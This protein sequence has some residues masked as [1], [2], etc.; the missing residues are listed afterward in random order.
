MKLWIASIGV[1]LIWTAEAFA[2]EG[3]HLLGPPENNPAEAVPPETPSSS[4]PASDASAI[5]VD[6]WIRGI[7]HKRIPIIGKSKAAVA[8]ALRRDLN[9]DSNNAWDSNNPYK[10]R[11][12]G[13]GKRASEGDCEPSGDS[14]LCIYRHREWRY[15]FVIQYLNDEAIH[16]VIIYGA[17]AEVLRELESWARAAAEVLK[18]RESTADY[19]IWT[20]ESMELTIN[21][22]E[23]T[24]IWYDRTK[25]ELIPDDGF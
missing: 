1:L 13:D 18:P 19:M 21:W 5:N 9:W 25:L 4:S 8:V 15:P 16:V 14:E 11:N 17:E 24:T 2:Q 20:G 12:R 7:E 22:S 6:E 10:P 3:K 23:G